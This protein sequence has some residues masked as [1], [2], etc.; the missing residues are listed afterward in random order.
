[1]DFAEIVVGEVQRD[2]VRVHFQFL[3]EGIR[4]PSESSHV[5]PHRE[6][7]PLHVR[8][9]DVSRGRV[10]CDG[11]ALGSGDLRRGVAVRCAAGVDEA[12]VVLFEHRV[13]DVDPEGVINGVQ[14]DLQLVRGQMDAVGESG[15]H[16]LHEVVGV[17][18]G[19]VADAIA[20]DQLGVGV[21]S[22]PRPDIAPFASLSL[23]HVLGLRAD[24]APDFIALNPLALE[25][26]HMGVVVGGACRSEVAEQLFDG[27]PSH[28]RHAGGAAQAVPFDQ[29][30][31]D[32]S[33][34]LG[35]QLVHEQTIQYIVE[36]AKG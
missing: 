2:V 28:A 5:H 23:G 4:E 7:L 24:E 3:A 21:D 35:A 22:R 25:A 1:M 31:D 13:I 18:G 30:G 17:N 27:H 10:A 9:A 15:G 14:I 32:P 29:G 12:P 20:D 16:V 26:P 36:Q 8:R 6:V 34:L 33:A 19:P 11:Y